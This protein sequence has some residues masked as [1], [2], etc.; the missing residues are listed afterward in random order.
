[1]PRRDDR[2]LLV[3]RLQGRQISSSAYDSQYEH[4]TVKMLQRL[5]ARG[6]PAYWTATHGDIVLVSDGERVS[7]RTQAK[8]PTD[9]GRLREGG[10]VEP[11][12]AGEVVARTVLNGH[13]MQGLRRRLRLT[14]APQRALESLR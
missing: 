9:P 2:V 5:N 4:P 8:A 12:S 10:L 13:N 14:V 6:I 7:V 1:M 11:G 3:A